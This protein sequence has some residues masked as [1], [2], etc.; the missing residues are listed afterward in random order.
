MDYQFLTTTML[1]R[2]MNANEAEAMLSC[3]GTYEKKYKKGELI[4]RAG[5]YT[6]NM[7][8]VLS[9]GANVVVDDLWGNTT[10]L[11]HAAP[12]QLFAEPYACIPGEPLLVNVIASANTEVLFLNAAKLLRTCKNACPFHNRLVQNLLQISEQKSLSLS[13]RGVH[14]APKSIR[15]R[16][17]SYLS[18]QAKR[19]GSYQFTIPFNRQQLADYLSVDRSAMSNELSKMQKEGLLHVH[20]NIFELMLKS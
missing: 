17:I 4:Y 16:L 18:E 11:V 6:Q 7:G 1:F 9:G 5:D 2:G 19:S 10:L 8:F 3:L 14:T 20:K 15:G 13:M 12:G